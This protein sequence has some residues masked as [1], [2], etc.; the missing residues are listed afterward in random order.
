LVHGEVTEATGTISAP[1]GRDADARPRWG[2][3]AGGRRAETGYRVLE[4]FVHVTLLEMEPVTGRTNQ[5][6]IHAAHMGHP[7]LGDPEFGR[8]CAERNTPLL[9]AVPPRLFL[10]AAHLAFRH[11]VSGEWL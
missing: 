7:I 4:R 2:V 1:I 10:H 3:R 9:P 11:P 6:R 8:E 5:L